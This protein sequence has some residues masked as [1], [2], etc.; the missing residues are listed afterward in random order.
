[1]NVKTIIIF[2]SDSFSEQKA[3]E[4][5][6][7]AAR[8]L[9]Q[10]VGAF[11][12]TRSELYR[13]SE[14]GEVEKRIPIPAQAIVVV[15]PKGGLEAAEIRATAKN[16]RVRCFLTETEPSE[17]LEHLGREWFWADRGSLRAAAWGLPGTLD[18]WDPMADN[19]SVEAAETDFYIGFGGC[20]RVRIPIQESG[21]VSCPFTTCE[22]R[23]TCFWARPA[24]SYDV[25]PRDAAQVR[26]A[27]LRWRGSWGGGF[28]GQPP[29]YYYSGEEV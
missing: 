21:W 2:R 11:S 28:H 3:L 10:I 9:G 19:I 12:A 13:L 5:A 25:D 6:K 27:Y 4:T 17:V 29:V 15:V 14:D 22:H 7:E 24:G 18:A 1:M 26:M 16:F 8:G 23:E 20:R